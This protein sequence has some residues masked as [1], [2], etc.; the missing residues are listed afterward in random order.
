LAI[1]AATILIVSVIISLTN[2]WFVGALVNNIQTGENFKK[3]LKR[4]SSVYWQLLAFDLITIVLSFFAFMRFFGFAL[5]TIFDILFF[6]SLPSIIKNGSFLEGMKTGFNLVKK[7]LVETGLVWF[8]TNIVNTVLFFGLFFLISLIFSPMLAELFSTN[9]DLN[10][11]TNFST[12][13]YVQIVGFVLEN[14]YYVMISAV[15][16]SLFLSVLMVFYY[17]V[18]S[19]WFLY[20]S[21][22]RL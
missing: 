5:K 7:K 19:Y 21:K 14:Y 18:E 16:A 17:T 9:Y 3:S 2:I 4:S 13:Q 6:V 8:L 15:V 1:S 10:T 12:Q 11:F 22:K 20:L